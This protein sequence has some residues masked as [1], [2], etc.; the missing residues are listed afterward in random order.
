MYSFLEMKKII[1]ILPFLLKKYVNYVIL[2]LLLTNLIGI[3]MISVVNG[4]VSSPRNKIIDE[5]YEKLIS[6][7]DLPEDCFSS[8]IGIFFISFI[9]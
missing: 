1:I 2:L 3:Q 4:E 8:Q 5:N 7:A 9:F 6:I